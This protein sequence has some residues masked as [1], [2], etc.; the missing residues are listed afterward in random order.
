MRRVLRPAE[1]AT[2]FRAYLPGSRSGEPKTLLELAMSP[3]EP[4]RSSVIWTD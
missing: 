3:I 1:F 2:W 4:I